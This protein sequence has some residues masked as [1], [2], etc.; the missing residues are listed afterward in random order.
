MSKTRDD[1]PTGT[2]PQQLSEITSHICTTGIRPQLMDSCL[3]EMFR[4]HFSD[5]RNLENPIY[6]RQAANAVARPVDYIWRPDFA[7]TGLIID[8]V[9]HWDPKQTEKTPGILLRCDDWEPLSIAIGD[10]LQNASQPEGVAYY[11]DILTGSHVIFSL[12]KTKAA[13]ATLSAEVYLFLRQLGPVFRKDLNLHRFKPVRWGA[14]L[15]VEDEGSENYA[16]PIVLAY[17]GSC[18]WMIRPEAPYL[19]GVEMDLEVN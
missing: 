17:A 12:G 14:A 7:D 15:V 10:H 13:A 1:F 16:V 3:V 8:T 5:P 2:F 18:R 11:E 6:R 4:T 19:T 9:D